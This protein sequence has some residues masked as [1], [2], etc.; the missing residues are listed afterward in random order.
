MCARILGISIFKTDQTECY[1]A[2]GDLIFCADTGQ[3]GA[4]RAGVVWPVPRFSEDDET[5][6]DHLTGL[7]WS[8]N[9]SVAEFPVMW[10]EALTF[11][12]GMNQRRTYGYTDW[13][14]PN[15]K[16]LFSLMSHV[17]TNPS[18][19]EGHPFTNVFSGYYWTANTC[20][21]LP[22][23][24]W[25][26]HLGGARVFKGMK[27]GSYMVWPVRNEGHGVVD[28]PRSGQQTC[29]DES[30]NVIQCPG[31]GQDASL[32]S[33]AQWPAMRF[34]EQHQGFLDRV[35]GLEWTSMAHC[36][37][38]TT[39]WESALKT[40]QSMNADRTHGNGDWRLPNIRELESL[41][42]MESHSPALPVGHPF[43]GVRES[44]WSSTTSTYD[45][46]YAWVVYMQDGAVGVGFKQQ[47]AFFTWAVR[48]GFS[49]PGR[50]QGIQKSPASPTIS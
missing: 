37:S 24:A 19:P 35:T 20:V 8:K 34:V 44:Y 12:G 38:T 15:R 29:Y 1:S 39:S 16:E 13:R 32:Q 50:G 33:G 7:M 30:G 10:R 4:V 43:R 40:I 47:S 42:D 5:V 36:S 14:L 6:I 28:L 11:V 49:E 21:R 46:R 17:K 3:D 41:C 25:Y 23:E 31:S 22:Q 18:L 48:G 2:I 27:H 45:P 9:A 26:V